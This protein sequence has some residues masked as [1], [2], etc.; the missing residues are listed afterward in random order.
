MGADDSKELQLDH[1]RAIPLSGNWDIRKVFAILPLCQA[2]VGPESAIINAASCFDVPKIC[3][4]S[5]SSYYNLTEYWNGNYS[6]KPDTAISPCYPCHQLHYTKASCPTV[7]MEYGETKMTELPVCTTAI[8]PER[9]YAQL[10]MLYN[11]WASG[12][13]L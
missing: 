5:H 7:D 1:Q 4:L 8:L 9:V 10:D 12:R 2:V 13:K 6:L 11:Q 3:M